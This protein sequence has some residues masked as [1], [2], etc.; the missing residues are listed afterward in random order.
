MTSSNLLRCFA[1]LF[2]IGLNSCTIPGNR[3]TTTDW[4]YGNPKGLTFKSIDHNGSAPPG[5]VFVPGGSFVMG[6]T[7][8]SVALDPDNTPKFASVSS[9]YMDE[10]E[11]PNVSYCEYISWMAKVF[12]Q[13]NPA[14]YRTCLPDT[15][16]WR[17]SLSFNE[18][19]VNDYLRHPAFKYYPVVGVSWVQANQYCEWRTDRVNEQRLID[20]GYI[21]YSAQ[22][23]E[24]HFT[25]KG[26]LAGFYRPELNKRKAKTGI[27]GDPLY[28][29]LEDGF[30]TASFRLPSEAEWEYAAQGMVGRT[31][32]GMIVE[33]RVYP[34]NERGIR[35]GPGKKQGVYH[36]NFR[37]SASSPSEVATYNVTRGGP[38]APGKYYDA[39][40]YGLYNMAGN[41]NE[42][43]QDL[44]RPTSN[45]ESEEVSP[46]L[47]GGYTR[48]L[49]DA[50]GNLAKDSAGRVVMVPD[51]RRYTDNLL[52]SY[53]DSITV[54]T[55]PNGPANNRNRVIKGG[56]YRDLPYWV[57]PGARRFFN[58]NRGKDDIGFRCA[59]IGLG[60]PRGQR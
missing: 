34:W 5:M 20:A 33:R 1:F 13:S 25:T 30:F 15:G 32:G 31:E 24:Q 16:V 17:N 43:V 59:M 51:E 46:F 18:P 27:G 14:T 12:A 29:V 28:P 37:F 40:D 41:V 42:W 50:E 36:G 56:S 6:S 53:L 38:T 8:E 7:A 55:S 19:H 23:G 54:T 44:Y 10:I 35:F 11:V 22:S 60:R 48:P 39:N 4:E 3:S 2:L 49:Y 58:E 45:I 9:F 26:Y 21:E 57:T 47:G 52:A